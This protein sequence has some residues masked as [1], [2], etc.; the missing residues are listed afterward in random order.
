MKKFK[1]MEE[2][3]MATSI[4]YSNAMSELLHYLK[5]IKKEDVN[6]IPKKLM[7][8]FESNASDDYKCEFDY[9]K[10]LN[11]LEK[12]LQ[13]ETRGLIV[14][15]CL[16]YWCETEEQKRILI[17]KLKENERQY[18]TELREKYNPDYLL[19]KKETRR[20]DLR[21]RYGDDHYLSTKL[22]KFQY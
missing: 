19:K 20:R 9:T 4:K 18:Q 12:E 15:I 10:P 8:Y 16:N 22:G 5:G 1:K 2:M 17:D 7:E 6:K 11:E 13:V 21:M 3:A 14:M